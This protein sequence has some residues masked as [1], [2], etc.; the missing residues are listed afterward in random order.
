MMNGPFANR[1]DELKS[2]DDAKSWDHSPFTVRTSHGQ[3]ARYFM[4]YSL[5]IGGVKRWL[6]LT[7]KPG[8]EETKD[9]TAR[10][11]GDHHGEQGE[12]KGTMDDWWSTSSMARRL[13][14]PQV[15][16]TEFKE[17][18]RYVN[19]FRPSAIVLES[20]TSLPPVEAET[21]TN[22]D[23]H[24][25]LS[26]PA[27]I[28]SGITRASNA[29][30]GSQR[31]NPLRHPDYRLFIDYLNTPSRDIAVLDKDQQVY[32]GYVDVTKIWVPG[33]EAR[34]AIESKR[35]DAYHRYVTTGKFVA[36]STKR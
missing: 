3:P 25:T 4:L 23:L 36:S 6:T 10:K 27:S 16:T 33:K 5:N 32:N 20:G 15:T 13:L 1:K 18:R 17:Y 26:R 28:A 9:S 30:T 31:D 7:N 22:D 35:Y 12:G 21:S 19:Q 8:D 34:S 29:S 11:S 2:S 24:S 14:Q